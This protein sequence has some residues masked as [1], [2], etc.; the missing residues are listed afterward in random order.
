MADLYKKFAEVYDECGISTFSIG[1]GKAML[2][3]LNSV[4][5]NERFEKNLDIC[6]GT[7]VLCN[8]LKENGIETKGVDISKEMLDVARKN[9][10]DIEFIE[11]DVK[12]YQDDKKYDFITC[13]DDALPHIINIDDIQM[14]IRNV[15][16]L[17]RE[18][19]LFIFDI[20]YFHLMPCE[21]YDKSIGKHRLSY[22]IQ[23]DDKIMTFN[24][25]CYEGDELIWTD[26]TQE[27]DYSI[28]EITSIL[29][30]EGF[31]IE[32]CSQHF[33]DE[34]R[35]EKWKIVAKKIE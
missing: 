21:K 12:E 25:E 6:C 23:R 22:E 4:Y 30:E 11:N 5:P 9:Y 16:H 27:R 24:V 1:F 18:N 34:K 13:T 35:C 15:N 28:E 33:F 17:L 7:G 31:V 10:P 8:F 2:K 19:G 32:T 26:T 20:N 3:Y 14:V 29:N